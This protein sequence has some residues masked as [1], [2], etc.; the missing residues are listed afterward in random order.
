MV[1][2]VTGSSSGAP[3]TIVRVQIW[4]VQIPYISPMQSSRG[5]LEAGDKVILRLHA[6]DGTVGL[7]EASVIF[8]ARDGECAD[9]VFRRLV[10]VITPHLLGKDGANI[11]VILH[12]LASLSSEQYA[13]PT[14]LCAVDLALHDLKA[15]HLGIAVA[16]LLGGAT[17][18]RF[19]LSRSMAMHD[20]DTTV[21]SACMLAEAGYRL[22]TLKGSADW[23]HDIRMARAVQR[24][25]GQDTRLE[26]D[27]NQAW[28]AKAALAVDAALQE[29][30][31]E[32]IE[33]PC[34]WWD[35][36]SMRQ[37]TQ[38]AHAPI[39]ADESVLNAAD[40]MR[41]AGSRAADI[42]TLKLAKSGGLRASA[43]ILQIALAGGLQ[44]NL[45][46]KHTL[47]VGTAALL[48]FAAAYPGSGE[49]VGYGSALERFAGDIVEQSMVIEEGQ[50]R[51]PPGPG[52]GVTLD[53]AALARFRVDSADLSVR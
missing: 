5:R 40:A 20:E 10:K 2:L 26:I 51:L 1:D 13:F 6:L 31:L 11:A 33:Q 14:S 50:V 46:S 18:T 23:R 38:R 32:C 48:H 34:A 15:R 22:L 8:P 21:R 30:Q 53:E 45:G 49:F 35:I 41:V 36:A 12:N 25:V 24:A 19:P 52:F 4:K 9:S 43:V 7:G 42:I 47:G 3:L 39:A 27:P 17:R 37:I 29:C 28:H 16:D 44:C